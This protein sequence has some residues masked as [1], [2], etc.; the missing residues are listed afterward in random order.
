MKAVNLG[1]GGL[2]FILGDDGGGFC[3]IEDW[4]WWVGGWYV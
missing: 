4:F 2:G 1:V 3:G